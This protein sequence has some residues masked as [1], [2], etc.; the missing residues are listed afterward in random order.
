MSKRR[1]MQLLKFIGILLFLGIVTR[2]DRAA[3]ADALRGTHWPLVLLAV[4][5]ILGISLTKALRWHV[6]VRAMGLRTTLKDAW[7]IYLIGTFLG[8]IT[9]GKVGELGRAAYLKQHGLTLRAG[10]MLSVVDRVLDALVVA[11]FGIWAVWILWSGQ[12]EFLMYA[13]LCLVLIAAATAF[14]CSKTTRT[15]AACVRFL[16]PFLRGPTMRAVLLTTIAGWALYFAWAIAIARS[17][18]IG[19]PAET[20]VAVFT[21]SGLI[22]ML[23]I[24]PSGLGT[25]DAALIF[26]LTP[27]GVQ[28][29]QALAQAVLMFF[30]IVL[31]SL[32]GG[33]YWLRGMRRGVTVLSARPRAGSGGATKAQPFAGNAREQALPEAPTAST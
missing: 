10:V 1:S 11:M 2:I 25:R 31:M 30:T 26:L 32:P 28:P 16:A 23:P 19:V 12:R 9:P 29:E 18:G 3:L 21:F 22:S 20:L 17:L 5:C 13:L 14:V 8:N 7:E 27:Y 4:L 24:A 33:W 6:L 15:A